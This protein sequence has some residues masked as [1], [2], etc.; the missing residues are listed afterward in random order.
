MK[1]Q[2]EYSIIEGGLNLF[3]LKIKTRAL[4]IKTMCR[5][6]FRES[7]D[8]NNTNSIECIKA[9]YGYGE[10]CMSII[11]LKTESSKYIYRELMYNTLNKNNSLIPSRNEKRTVG[12]KLS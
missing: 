1:D 6:F 8:L 2:F 5:M 4:L 12:V 11:K 7:G 9:M 10:D 3:N